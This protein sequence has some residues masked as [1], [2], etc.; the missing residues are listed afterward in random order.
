MLGTRSTHSCRS[1][2]RMLGHLVPRSGTRR[3]FTVHTA[4]AHTMIT[5]VTAHSTPGSPRPHNAHMI[6]VLA[7]C[8]RYHW[9][10]ARGSTAARN[11]GYAQR[12]GGDRARR[13]VGAKGLWA[14]VWPRVPID[15]RR[16]SMPVP[17]RTVLRAHGDRA[18]G[19]CT[20]TWLVAGESPAGARPI[21][22]CALQIRGAHIGD[23]GSGTR[24]AAQAENCPGPQQGHRDRAALIRSYQYVMCIRRGHPDARRGLR[25]QEAWARSRGGLRQCD[26]P[27]EARLECVETRRAGDAERA[28]ARVRAGPSARGGEDADWMRGPS[29]FARTFVTADARSLPL[30]A[31]ASS[32]PR[33]LY[34]KPMRGSEAKRKHSRWPG[35][36]GRARGPRSGCTEARARAIGAWR[37]GARHD[38][39]SARRDISVRADGRIVMGGRASAPCARCGITGGVG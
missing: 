31:R 21:S 19:C 10:W 24:G 26:D 12:C 25:D 30:R 33:W 5:A 39:I 6:L 14:V 37:G 27:G 22:R 16:R 36:V 28:P 13:I 11:A 17:Q 8:D 34:R 38:S 1:P 7:L 29:R 20:H 9:G 35:R 32:V 15:P 3:P 4:H 2:C 23:P 18:D